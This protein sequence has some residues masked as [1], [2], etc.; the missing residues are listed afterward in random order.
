MSVTQENGE[1]GEQEVVNLVRCP[2]CGKELIRLATNNPL[3]DV[4]C[5]ACTF[6][7]QIKTAH[8]KP[9]SVI[10]GAGWDIMEKVLKA[11]ILPPLLILNFKWK[12]K[13][14]LHHEIRFY[15]F[16]PKQNLKKYKLSST[17]K[18]ANYRMFNYVDMDKLPYFPLYS[19]SYKN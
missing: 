13:G 17:A 9:S 16:V 18:R 14:I 19:K 7:A 8:H 11:G 4:Q 1:A 5:T 2:N 10:Q 12:E 3:Y 6:R 15:P